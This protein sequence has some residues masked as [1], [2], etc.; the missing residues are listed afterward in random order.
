MRRERAREGARL[1]A[2][3]PRMGIMEELLSA[4]SLSAIH[5]AVIDR[6]CSVRDIASWYVARIEAFGMAGGLN[7]VRVVSPRVME[8]AQELDNETSAGRIRGP[9]HGIPI[10]L[11]DNILTGDGMSAAAGAAALLDF[12][13]KRDA[14]LVSRLRNAGA[15]I[16]GKTN[17]TEFAD[18]VSDVMP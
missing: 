13:P 6:K 15:L 1:A 9:L 14:T 16:L 18:Y 2:V 3:M 5:Q 4:S 11:K 17:L 10:L 12:T 8:Q 7:A